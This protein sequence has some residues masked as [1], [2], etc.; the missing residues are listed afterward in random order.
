MRPERDGADRLPPQSR[1]AERSVLGSMLRDNRKIDDVALVVTVDHFYSD[2]HQRIYQAISSLHERQIPV[3]LVTLAE[4]LRK[5]GEIEDIGGYAYLGELF[6]AAP[7]A[8]NAEHY[9]G[10]VKE[11]ALIRGVIH[12]STEI[13]RD[14]Y[15][16]VMSAEELVA[17]AERRIMEVG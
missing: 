4:E 12:T 6:E 5:R 7:T 8:A 11:R 9:A 17:S 2:A 13:L 14:A 1:E 10:I 3:D 15:D 16:N